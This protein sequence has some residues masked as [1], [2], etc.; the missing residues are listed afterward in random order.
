MVWHRKASAHFLPEGIQC[1][2]LVAHQLS[3]M[4]HFVIMPQTS[5]S[6]PGTWEYVH[7]DH[8]IIFQQT[9]KNQSC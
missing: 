8:E 4:G 6:R 7:P 5:D 2:R 1:L 3:Q 9:R